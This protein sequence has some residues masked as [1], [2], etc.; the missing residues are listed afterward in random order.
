MIKGQRAPTRNQNPR[1]PN[2]N[3]VVIR[4]S[5][6]SLKAKPREGTS[7]KL[8]KPLASSRNRHSRKLYY[9][10]DEKD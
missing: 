10:D 7:K 9:N 4:S 3:E 5:S 1:K 2:S 6:G 8:I